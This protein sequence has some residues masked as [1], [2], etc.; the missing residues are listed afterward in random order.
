M[1]DRT[2]AAILI[3]IGTFKLADY[4]FTLRAIFVL[5]APEANPLIDVMLGTPWFAVV[6]IILPAIGL[7]AIWRFRNRARPLFHYALLIPF[8]AYAW[9]TLHHAWWQ[10]TLR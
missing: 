2:L 7:Y 10:I 9:L 6:K 4:L 3:S 5:G 1:R 8:A